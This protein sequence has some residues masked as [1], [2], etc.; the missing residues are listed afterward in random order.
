MIPDRAGEVPG[1]AVHQLQ[2]VA[3]RDVGDHAAL[4]RDDLGGAAQREAHC[5]GG[6]VRVGVAECLEAGEALG[7]AGAGQAPG[8]RSLA[9]PAGD[10]AGERG[11][12]DVTAGR[13]DQGS[14]QLSPQP[15]RFPSVLA[16]PGD[17]LLPPVPSRSVGAAGHPPLLPG[18]ARLIRQPVQEP[19][20][21]PPA[22]FLA[23]FVVQHEYPAGEPLEG[24]IAA[25]PGGRPV[26]RRR[27]RRERCPGRLAAGLRR[28]G[29]DPRER[30]G[31]GHDVRP[32]NS[33]S[34]VSGR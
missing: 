5:L 19:L 31:P 26:R 8:Q 7:V 28:P 29:R 32:P 1:L 13:H 16:L 14:G 24:L 2:H 23:G 33:T 17:R 3:D 6:H 21:G 30:D 10:Q 12:D 20:Q 27:P 15:P 11:T 9:R 25:L 22:P 34:I 18:L 4:G